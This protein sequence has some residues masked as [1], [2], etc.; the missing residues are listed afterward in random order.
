MTGGVDL[1][2]RL[3]K[4]RLGTPFG[5]IVGYRPGNVIRF[6]GVIMEEKTANFKG[7]ASTVSGARACQKREN[8]HFF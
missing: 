5:S 3:N 1:S 4:G 7:G 2:E 6:W 8:S